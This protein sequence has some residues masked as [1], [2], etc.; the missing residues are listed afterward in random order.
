[1]AGQLLLELL[2]TAG[3]RRSD[4]ADRHRELPRHL[5]VAAGGLLV[6]EGAQELAA[7]LVDPRE[8]ERDAAALLDLDER[9]AG[10]AARAESR[11]VVRHSASLA[12][13]SRPRSACRSARGMLRGKRRLRRATIRATRAGDTSGR[14]WTKSAT[15]PEAN[16]AAN[17]VPLHVA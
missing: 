13:S 16:A 17:D 7:A 8:T 10:Q 3:A 15:P 9:R 12:R 6:V 4:A 14:F 1:M 2:E 5:A 11:V